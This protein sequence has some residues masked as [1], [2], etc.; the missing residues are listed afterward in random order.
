MAVQAP[1]RP[2][3]A[4]TFDAPDSGVI[5]DARVRQRRQRRVGI[6]AAAALAI[7]GLVAYFAGGGGGARARGLARDG[8]AAVVARAH[9]VTSVSLRATGYGLFI[10]PDLS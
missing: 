10:G 6:A 9:G 7:A 2:S 3:P 4:P 1:D 5:E 8:S